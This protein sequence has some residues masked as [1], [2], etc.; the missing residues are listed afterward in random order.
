M[1]FR[2]ESA[3][4]DS[5]GRIDWQIAKRRSQIKK[6]EEGPEKDL[7]LMAGKAKASVRAFV[8]HPFYLLKKLFR[9]RKTCYRGLAK[10]SSPTSS[11]HW[12][13]QPRG[14]SS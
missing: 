13:G 5:T 2:D 9:H 7:I 6:L 1:V 3:V 4:E 12:L 8:A 14:Y 10:K 11:V